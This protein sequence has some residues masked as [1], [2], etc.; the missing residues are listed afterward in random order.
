MS[1]FALAAMGMAMTSCNKEEA[2]TAED[3]NLAFED[4]EVM[5]QVKT[6]FVG[7]DQY[8]DNDDRIYIMDGSN[9]GA[10]YR[11]STTDNGAT[12]HFVFEANEFGNFSITNGELTAFYPFNIVYNRKPD[13]VLLP[14]LQNT[15]AGE[16]RNFPM[17]GKGEVDNF[18]WRNLCALM[19]FRLTGDVALDSISIT[20]DKY[21]NGHFKVN[22]AN[23]DN[24]LSYQSGGYAVLAHGTKTNTLRFASP[25]QLNGTEQEA[26]IFLPAGTYKS[27]TI[28]FYANGQRY[29][30]YNRNNITI[31]RSHF[32]Y[33]SAPL[34]SADFE[35]YTPGTLNSQF[36][37]A[38]AGEPARYVVFS[39]GN[40]EYVSAPHQ[41]WRF[42]DNQWDFRGIYQAKDGNNQYDRDLFAWGANGYFKD[43]HTTAGYGNAYKVWRTNNE[44]TYY[45]G[46]E[47]TDM[48]N[49][50]NNA[51]ANAENQTYSG[52]RCLT[53]TEMTNLLNNHAYRHVTLGFVNKMG[54]V[55]FPNGVTPVENHT[56]LTKTE[57]NALQ[58]AGCVFFLAEK[59]RQPDGTIPNTSNHYSAFWL[60]DA[61]SADM[62]MYFSAFDNGWGNAYGL[63]QIGA[64]VRL[65][66]DVQ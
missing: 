11:A 45:G 14:S 28:T 60:S 4:T 59:Y 50:G 40:L 54:I 61:H 57:W 52:W 63:K 23:L 48:N 55:F 3:L 13:A 62:A 25:L 31:A 6:H 10:Y 8:W 47:L 42:A 51:I 65:V 26:S 27:F 37:V 41:Y 43:G 9:N 35:D 44:Y 2:T 22:I 18:V 66:K 38:G 21:I 29:V 5:N 53:H 20:T 32:N 15:E 34:N 64:F 39:Q 56:T 7:N 33:M 19:T 1:I 24:P 17:Y 12:A 58:E 36:N 16:I 46:M 49:W 30:K